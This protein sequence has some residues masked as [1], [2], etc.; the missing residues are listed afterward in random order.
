MNRLLT[1]LTG[2][3]LYGLATP[4]SDTDLIV[5]E[6][7]PWEKVIGLSDVCMPSQKIENGIDTRVYPL[8]HFAKLAAT[9]NPAVLE[10]LFARR[11][12]YQN[13]LP[14]W[15]YLRGARDSFL[16]ERVRVAYLGFAERELSK[17]DADA[18]SVATAVR[19][20]MQLEDILTYHCFDPTLQGAS[21]KIVAGIRAGEINTEHGRDIAQHI[22]DK[23]ADMTN[24]LPREPD[25][26]RINHRLLGI[27]R[28]FYD[29]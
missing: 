16:S 10:V 25:I 22:M 5:I 11:D 23:C 4:S 3:R 24:S 20:M 2:S 6:V 7:E 21:L 29:W 1:V 19:L 12:Y 9:G 17:K 28:N 15:E 8:H 13:Y 18:K 26:D 27:Y 14:E